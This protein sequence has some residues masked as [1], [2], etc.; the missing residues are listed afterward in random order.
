MLDRLHYSAGLRKPWCSP[1]K[2]EEVARDREVNKLHQLNVSDAE[3]QKQAPVLWML[4]LYLIIHWTSN[5]KKC[6][7]GKLSG[8]ILACCSEQVRTY[9]GNTFY[10]H[11]I[12]GSSCSCDSVWVKT[13]FVYIEILNMDEFGVFSA[14]FQSSLTVFCSFPVI[15]ASIIILFISAALLLLSVH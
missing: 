5:F 15:L 13:I 4:N 10:L 12:P 7:L 8:L 9:E 14:C 1:H 3:E 11:F 2:L 6:V